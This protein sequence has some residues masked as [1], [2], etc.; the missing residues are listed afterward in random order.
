MASGN[1]IK[2]IDRESVHRICS[3]QVVL[4]MATAVKEL[5]ENS[6][7]AGSTSIVVKFKQNGLEYITVTDNGCGIT[8]A[9]LETLA[10]KHYTSKLRSFND[11]ASVRSFGFRG[12]ALS[13]LCALA[14]V[15]VT[16]STG[17]APTGLLVEYN[18][19]GVIQS[20]TPAPMTKGTIVK[21]SNLFEGMPVRRSEFVKNIKREYNKCI[22]LVQAYALIATNVRI[23]CV[24][25][26]DKKPAVTYIATS[27]NATVRQNIINVFGPK[28]M[29]DLIDFELKLVEGKLKSPSNKERANSDGEQEGGDG[30]DQD[31]DEQD[32]EIILTGHISSP[33]FGKGRSSTDRQ[34]LF[35]N[36]RPC[37]LPKIARVIN[38]V[39]HSFNTNQS[40]FLVANLILPTAAYDVNVSPDKRTIFLH[41]ERRIVEEL[42]NELTKLFEPSRSTFA[43]SQASQLIKK[44]DLASRLKSS[45]AFS[46]HGDGEPR[47]DDEG[48]EGKHED[49]DEYLGRVRDHSTAASIHRP[50]IASIE[51]VT[52]TSLSRA[53]SVAR[54][55]PDSTATMATRLQQ[56]T[57]TEKMYV[58]ESSDRRKRKLS[59]GVSG[60]EGEEEPLFNV[61]AARRV[62]QAL[63]ERK[64]ADGEGAKRDQDE[65]TSLDR[66]TEGPP[67]SPLDLDV[68]ETYDPLDDKI[69]EEEE[70]NSTKP[71][72]VVVLDSVVREDGDREWI[73]VEFDMDEHRRKRALRMKILQETRRL[74]QERAFLRKEKAKA[75]ALDLQR[76]AAAAE[77]TVTRGSEKQTG[78]SEEGDMD[79]EGSQRALR[80][81]RRLRSQKLSDAS[82]A[83]MDDDKAQQSLSRVI[84]KEDFQRM[85]ILGQFNKAFI[86]ARLDN[87]ANIEQDNNERKDITGSKRDVRRGTLLSSDI[88]VIDQH[89]SDEK[90]N[91]ETL[92]AKTVFSTQRLFQPKKLHLTAQEEITVVDHMKMLN[93]NGFYLDYDPQAQ[94]SHRLQLVTLPVSE[95]VVFDLQDFE[96]L[97]FLL[98]Q[99][100]ASSY[101]SLGGEDDD[102]GSEYWKSNAKFFCRFCKIYITD[103]K[104]TRNIHDQGTKHKENVER[105]LREQNQRG[106]DR[107]AE[108]ARMDKQMDAIEKAAMRQYQL[109]VEAGLVQPTAAMKAA[110]SEATS[111]AAKSSTKDS[112]PIPTGLLKL[113]STPTPAP[114][115]ETTT[116]HTA[117]AD[118]S[119]EGGTDVGSGTEPVA[120]IAPV[121]AKKDETIGQPGEWETVDV[122]NVS[123]SQQNKKDT[124][125]GPSSVIVDEDED[126]AGNP[127]DLRRFKIVEKTYPLDD[128]DLA[129][130]GEGAGGG[131]AVFKK[132]KGG[133]GKPRNIRRKL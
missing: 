130:E 13:S 76:S 28:A 5:L 51:A 96:E 8:D 33:S 122:H 81:S 11:L 12:E 98:S 82:F 132:R 50:V 68:M 108:S 10:L 4:D 75:R 1:A 59:E 45:T 92:Q 115:P 72:R 66:R 129:G 43:V 31:D 86:V 32:Q 22:G 18:S 3:G 46:L 20:K 40:P 120:A 88:F 80:R 62:D 47:H 113:S 103:N 38:E 97:V 109:D 35:I 42:R 89:A 67:G 107:E 44:P 39:Y 84:S 126:V 105:F 128:D 2:A 104:S 127:E 36:G 52:L 79:T 74:E 73:E 55:S 53:S 114:A 118:V 91:F 19:D 49:E 54:S 85:K 29:A 112:E 121:K 102:D 58:D 23:S 17:A 14:H 16:T 90:Y 117:I 78:G 70:D 48:M 87:Y 41:N 15:T 95:K 57:L 133:V 110:Q 61:R 60:S 34:Y 93:M 9:N 100:T 116:T 94:V 6:L 101:G 25:Q 65:E 111:S 99:Q 83:N 125:D 131:S 21:I 123:S 119:G 106:R 26:L 63:V 30:D 27:G 77:E 69:R 64:V 124:K 24:S 56:T 7:D 37:V 71:Q